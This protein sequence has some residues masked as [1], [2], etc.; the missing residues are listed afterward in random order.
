MRELDLGDNSTKQIV[1]KLL[2]RKDYVVY[3]INL[4]LYLS[5]G[6]TVTN[7]NQLPAFQQKP[8]FQEYIDFSTNIRKVAKNNFKKDF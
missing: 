5:L 6:M 7:D 3:Q 4:K 8:C 2:K 1:P